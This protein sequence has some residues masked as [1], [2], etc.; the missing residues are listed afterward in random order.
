MN[1]LNLLAEAQV[2]VLLTPTLSL[3]NFPTSTSPALV[4][5]DYVLEDSECGFVC[6][7]TPSCFSFNLGVFSAFMGKVLCELLPSDVFNNSD[8]FVYSQSHH[9]YSI[10]VRNLL[11]C[12]LLNHKLNKTKPKKTRTKLGLQ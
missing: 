5:A 2:K 10:T 3:K 1:A 6:A 8:K 9:H 11:K 12:S 7:N 4:T